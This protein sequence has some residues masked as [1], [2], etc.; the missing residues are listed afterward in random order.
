MRSVIRSLICFKSFADCERLISFIK[1]PGLLA[2]ATSKSCSEI[3]PFTTDLLVPSNVTHKWVTLCF[4]I[5][6]WASAKETFS[7]TVTTGEDM[8]L[9]I[10]SVIGK[11]PVATLA[12]IS[13]CVTTPIGILSSQIIMLLIKLLVIVCATS[14]ITSFIVEVNGDLL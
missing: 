10:V 1:T 9:S 5:S 4:N 13:V 7:I 6:N 8:I 3:T 11:R 2:W 12:H 14:F